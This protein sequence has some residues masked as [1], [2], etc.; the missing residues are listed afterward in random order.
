M[1]MVN[2]VTNRVKLSWVGI[3]EEARRDICTIYETVNIDFH[4]KL[5]LSMYLMSPKHIQYYFSVNR[6]RLK[7]LIKSL[8]KKN[9]Y[10]YDFLYSN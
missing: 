7:T 9:V 10:A 3:L 4:L 5:L 8:N 1:C 2:V 6:I